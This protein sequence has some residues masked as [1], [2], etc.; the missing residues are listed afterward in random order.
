MFVASDIFPSLE[1]VYDDPYF[2]EADPYYGGQAVREL[3]TEIVREIP[4]AGIYNVDYQEMNSLMSEQI[5]RFAIGQV[6][7][8]EALA[9]AARE[10]RSRTGRR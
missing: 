1:T 2:S 3:F 8:S 5:Q 9:A 4:D 7:A 10:I 6:T